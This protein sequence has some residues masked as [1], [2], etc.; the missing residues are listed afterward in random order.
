[1]F[2]IEP[3]EENIKIAMEELNELKAKLFIEKSNCFNLLKPYRDKLSE[4]ELKEE[5]HENI[6]FDLM[7]AQDLYED[8]LEKLCDEIMSLEDN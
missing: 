8:V 1:M 7:I 2:I 5:K 4:I 6:L 3:Y